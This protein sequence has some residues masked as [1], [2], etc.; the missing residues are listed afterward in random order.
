MVNGCGRRFDAIA[1]TPCLL[2]YY[3]YREAMAEEQEFPPIITQVHVNKQ[4]IDK[5]YFLNRACHRVHYR[6]EKNFLL[7]Q[8]KQSLVALLTLNLATNS[9][10]R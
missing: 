3:G 6:V 1:I 7:L 10:Y 9:R 4:Y 2:A 8:S 5:Y